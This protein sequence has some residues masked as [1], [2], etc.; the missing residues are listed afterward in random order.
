MPKNRGA[1]GADVINIAPAI[2]VPDGRALS[3]LNEE[4]LPPEPAKGAPSPE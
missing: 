1:P 4:G 2:D 3:P